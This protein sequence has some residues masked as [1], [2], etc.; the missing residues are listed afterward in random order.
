MRRDLHH[1]VATA[2]VTLLTQA[3]PPAAVDITATTDKDSDLDIPLLADNA[4]PSP[5]DTIQVTQVDAASALEF[6]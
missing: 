2:N 6:R 3:V 5:G 1:A 4:D